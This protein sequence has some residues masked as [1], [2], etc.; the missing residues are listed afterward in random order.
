MATIKYLIKGTKN[1]SNVYV[2]IRNGRSVDVTCPTKYLVNPIEWSKTKGQPK[3][4]SESSKNLNADLELLRAKIVKRMND[5]SVGNKIDLNW[6][7]SIINPV[8]S[9]VK[10]L[11][12][13]LV[14]Y[15]DVYIDDK[16]NTATLSTIKKSKVFK[17]MLIRMMEETR[18]N[19]LIENVDLN[20]KSRFEKYCFK[21]KYS[22][23]TVARAIKFIK[24]ICRHAKMNGLNTHYQLDDLKGKSQ[25]VDHIH[26][27]FD[28]I[29]NIR[30]TKDLPEYL[31][32]ARDWLI[33]SCYTGQRISDFMRFNSEMI[34][35]IESKKII[36][37][38]QVKTG[39]EVPLPI[40]PIVNEIL[41]KRNGEFPRRISDQ[42]YNEYIKE[43][44]K[45][46]K[47]TDS[48]FGGKR[49]PETNRKQEGYYEK[50][51]LV[52]SHI[53]RR[54]F[55]TNFRGII[56]TPYLISATGH[57]TEQQFLAY[58]GKSDTYNAI[59]L[60]EYF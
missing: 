17:Q 9:N 27:T 25:K 31:D 26:L 50:W 39:K 32:N 6:V 10:E 51:E 29:E 35:E 58:V 53:G 37:F 20:F 13:D 24:T 19:V 38:T 60:A 28:E 14:G 2:R 57:S 48:V 43:V 42:K 34:K 49:N 23:N 44:C 4:K 56:P 59:Q 1:P 55:A 15:V 40:H 33:V 36:E 8:D 12:F 21:H 54:S 7:K 16:V 11:P 41:N 46:A 47:L 22:P 52:A 5:N 45:E 3:L 30:L 18:E